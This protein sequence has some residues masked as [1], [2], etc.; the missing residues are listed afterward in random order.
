M[1]RVKRK[2]KQEI[3]LNLFEK[4]VSYFSS[5]KAK[6]ILQNRF[7]IQMAGA[8]TG[9]N[10]S[11]RS[12]KGWLTT[13]GDADSDLLGD[14][15]TLVDRSRDSYRNNPIAAG[16]INTNVIHV[17]GAGLKFQ[18]HIDFKFLGLSEEEAEER[19][20]LIEKEF[21]C[22]AESPDCD[23]ERKKNFY[24]FTDLVYR[25]MLVSGD[26]FIPLLFQKLKHGIYG[27][28]L[29]AIEADRVS[30]PDDDQDTETIAG[31]VEKNKDGSP[32]KYHIKTVHPGSEITGAEEKWEPVDAFTPSGR[33]NMIH[34]YKELRPNQSRGIPYLSIVLSHFKQLD[35]FTDATLQDAVVSSL[36][37]AFISSKGRE[38]IQTFDQ[39]ETGGSAT[40][41]DYKMG[42]ASILYLDPS[43]EESVTFADPGRPNANFDAFVKSILTQAGAGLSQP[44]DILRMSFDKSYSAARSSLLMA[45]SF[46][47]TQRESL[48]KD[49]C[50]PVFDRF[51]EEAVLLG[52]IDA[53]GFLDDPLIRKAY[54]RGVWVGPAQGQI[55]P[56]K[57]IN[58]AEKRVKLTL[59]TLAEE[60]AA[61]NGGDWDTSI[62]RTI[63]E[64][65]ILKDN[66]IET[67]IQETGGEIL[68]EEEVVDDEDETKDEQ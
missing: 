52:R 66:N 18:S 10:K 2:E 57:E 37:T 48:V 30:N 49:W 53:P 38:E 9:A 35:A 8:Y 12:L 32:K 60:K 6:E 68:E 56:L 22:W 61:Y 42:P 1:K 20:N 26:I 64:R 11:K 44:L 28:R 59:T 21:N 41:E 34:L 54:T 50:E 27:L 67:G 63:K 19:Q 24:A 47:S 4:T 58:S 17:V 46:W 55:D 23:I 15:V 33:R 25:S 65:K 40:D 45:W 29:Q 43:Q 16:S 5:K 62:N 3:K 7:T 13:S 36:F 31:G 14:R 39:E 51:M